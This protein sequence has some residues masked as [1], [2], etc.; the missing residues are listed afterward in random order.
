MTRILH[1]IILDYPKNKNLSNDASKH[2]S[3]GFLF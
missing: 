3:E 2:E 1:V